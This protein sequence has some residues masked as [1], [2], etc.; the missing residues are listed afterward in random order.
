MHPPAD[1]REYLAQLSEIDAKVHAQA[2]AQVD[3]NT[4][5]TS[6]GGC[7]EHLPPSRSSQTYYLDQCALVP[8]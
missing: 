3:A 5:C 7:L 1:D 2:K 6:E 8:G 4:A